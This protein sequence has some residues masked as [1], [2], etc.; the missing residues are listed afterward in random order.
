MLGLG[1]SLSGNPLLIFSLILGFCYD[2][3]VDLGKL[4]HWASVSPPVQ[5]HPLCLLSGTGTTP[6]IPWQRCPCLSL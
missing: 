6:C 1:G 3:L 4:P 2:Q 5:A